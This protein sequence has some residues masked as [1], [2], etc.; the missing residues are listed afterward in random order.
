M[1]P[2][3]SVTLV[4]GDRGGSAAPDAP[5]QVHPRSR[6]DLPD[7]DGQGAGPTLSVRG[8]PGERL[9]A[10]EEGRT[11]LKLD[12]WAIPARLMV[13]ACLQPRV[14]GLAA[15]KVL[16]FRPV[17]R[18]PLAMALLELNLKESQISLDRPTSRRSV[19]RDSTSRAFSPSLDIEK[20]RRDVLGGEMISGTRTS[21][22]PTIAM[23]LCLRLEL[24]ETCV[25]IGYLT[26]DQGN[27]VD[28]LVVLR[29]ALQY[30]ERLPADPGSLR[31]IQFGLYR[32][33]HAIAA[34][35]SDL[36]DVESHGETTHLFCVGS[37][38]D[39][40]AGATTSLVLREAGRRFEAAPTNLS[41]I[42]KDKLGA[43]SKATSRFWRFRRTPGSSK[44]RRDV[45]FKNDLALTYLQSRI[46]GERNWQENQA[47]PGA[48][49]CI[50]QTTCR[51]AARW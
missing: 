10:L 40:P 19:P 20:V 14:A 25:R 21:S 12:P 47:A 18:C 6:V 29:Q 11:R 36:S 49:A 30:Y 46:P 45:D 7:G 5:G 27:K 9:E 43:R 1:T 26:K 34:V 28:A 3:A 17:S 4:R 48:G 44:I 23:T 35:E 39:R 31:R 41:L 42:A 33:L 2:Y 51:A 15:A 22:R 37:R 13:G 50:L 32:C 8:C 24:A 16:V 38:K